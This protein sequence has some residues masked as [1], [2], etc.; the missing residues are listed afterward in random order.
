MGAPAVLDSKPAHLIST[1][2][3]I[4]LFLIVFAE[5]GLLIGFFL[6]GDSLLASPAPT[7]RPMR[8]A[9]NRT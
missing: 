2:G 4:G 9:A 5:T 6:P 8:R 7:A 1:Y 3:T